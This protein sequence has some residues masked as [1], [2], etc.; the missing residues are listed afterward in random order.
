MEVIR[1][2]I[3]PTE[4]NHTIELPR[5][6]FGKEIEVIFNVRNTTK[7]LPKA[8]KIDLNSLFEQFGKGQ[9]FPTT[10]E[11]RKQSWAKK[12]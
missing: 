5:T 7:S 11:I 9:D 1:E 12:W 10:D 4:E 3:I 8:K 2:I 6:L